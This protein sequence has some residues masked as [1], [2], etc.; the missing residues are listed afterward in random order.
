MTN[1]LELLCLKTKVRLANDY[2]NNLLRD[3]K[4]VN[5]IDIYSVVTREMRSKVVINEAGLT[6]DNYVEFV[7]MRV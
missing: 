1:K 4:K 2:L 6:H 5:N 7:T 3:G